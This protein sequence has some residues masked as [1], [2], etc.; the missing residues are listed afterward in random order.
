MGRI[1]AV[2]DVTSGQPV[3]IGTLR[4]SEVPIG[5]EPGQNGITLDTAGVSRVHGIFY[6]VRNHWLYKDNGSTNGSWVGGHRVGATR[7]SVV[8][9]G[10]I[11]QLADCGV[12]V[13]EMDERGEQRQSLNNF[14]SLGGRTLLVFTHGE[15]SEEFPVPEY[16]KALRIGG[17]NCDLEYPGYSGS[18]SLIVIERRG[19][20]VLLTA[21]S[22]E[23]HISLNGNLIDGEHKLVD[24]DWILSGDYGI[25]L[26][27]PQQAEGRAGED[28]SIT[29][30]SIQGWRNTA[31]KDSSGVA[32]VKS[33]RSGLFG[34]QTDEQ[35][36]DTDDD[37]I[38][39]QGTLGT[40]TGIYSTRRFADTNEKRPNNFSYS[41]LEDKIM[42]GLLVVVIAALVFLLLWWLI[43]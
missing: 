5:R 37:I 33:P 11:V 15:F 28:G 34:M 24:N 22:A 19:D 18:G 31:T 23:Y 26:N 7:W 10:I 8:R 29:S 30:T 41:L 14:S 25:L 2:E 12:R 6:K 9:D 38:D 42:V 35:L 43:Q 4:G 36:A 39:T 20:Q 1:L 16:G 17:S 21:S 27:I 3:L 32:S 40:N 13:S